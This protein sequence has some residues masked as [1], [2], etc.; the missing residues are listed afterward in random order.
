MKR[1]LSSIGIGSATV[2]TILPGTEL[3]P[4]ET[5]EAIVEMEGGDS[6]QTIEAITLQLGTGVDGE[7]VVLDTFEI[8]GSFTLAT[9]ESRT[10]RTDVTL[11]PWT[12]ITRSD[13]SVWL[14]TVL[15]IEWAVDPSDEDA[16][17]VVPGP[18][19][20]ALFEAV[21]DLGF[22]YLTSSIE[23][24]HRLDDH[25]F[26]QTFTF[27]AD[28]GPFQDDLDGLTVTPV[29]QDDGLRTVVEIDEDEVAED[30]TGH[31]FDRHEVTVT[32]ETD[33]VA[34]MGRRLKSTI[35]RHTHT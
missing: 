4:G 29:P 20:E 27:A 34:M 22:S 15:D 23:D 12:P 35:E 9:D 1:V 7:D 16:I 8:P 5:V 30:R 33:N 25:P 24:V 31:D 28:D 10:A 14:R 2:D 17:D 13:Q 18:Y 6:D 26:A 21:D 3:H 11:P 19:L 32:F